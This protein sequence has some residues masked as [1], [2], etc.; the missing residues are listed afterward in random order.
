MVK[1]VNENEP[2]DKYYIIW[3]IGDPFTYS[4][5]TVDKF[6]KAFYNE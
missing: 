4:R 3:K 5:K 2:S 6:I 1:I